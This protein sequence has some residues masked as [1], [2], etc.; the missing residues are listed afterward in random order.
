MPAS[1]W[2]SSAL[3]QR[4]STRLLSLWT[5]WGS[6]ICHR[7]FISNFIK[8]KW[9]QSAV[10]K[11]SHWWDRQNISVQCSQLYPSDGLSESIN[12]CLFGWAPGEKIGLHLEARFYEKHL[13]WNWNITPWS[14][15]RVLWERRFTRGGAD[16][17]LPSH[18][19]IPVVTS[20]FKCKCIQF[21]LHTAT[22]QG[23]STTCA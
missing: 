17:Q 4:S 8:Q 23:L 18:T 6:Y 13:P 10:R 5:L 15:G 3:R 22:L 21:L 2:R 14:K 1:N 20:Y 16:S 12:R 9:S 11:A 19:P 7:S